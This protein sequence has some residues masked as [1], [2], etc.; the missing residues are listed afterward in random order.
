MVLDCFRGPGLGIPYSLTWL[1]K[2]RSDL[3]HGNFT[4]KSLNKLFSNSTKDKKKH[5]A[6][7]KE[8]SD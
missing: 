8:I 7:V 3:M 5:E 4:I 1:H 6:I 2:Q